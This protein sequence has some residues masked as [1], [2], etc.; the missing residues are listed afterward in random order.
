[1][2]DLVRSICRDQHRLEGITL[3]G[4]EPLQQP[5]GLLRLLRAVR[6]ETPLSSVLFSGYELG[7][8]ERLPYGKSI[9]A[10]LDVLVAGRYLREHHLGS[11]LRGSSN[12]TVHLLSDRY[13]LREIE[14]TPEGE[15]HI[16]PGG[17]ILITGVG[18]I[19]VRT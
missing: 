9:L 11:G 10:E 1:V 16:E 18:G 8:I 15:V 7:E 12:Q 5:R 19:A 4:G 17:R 6:R 13:F 14:R 3:S 2:S